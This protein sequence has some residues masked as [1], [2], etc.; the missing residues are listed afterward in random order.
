MIREAKP[1]LNSDY[2]NLIDVKITRKN[3]KWYLNTTEDKLKLIK[4]ILDKT[5]TK[6][7]NIDNRIVY[8]LILRIRTLH[9]IKKLIKK[10][11]YSKNDFVRVIEGIS[12][13]SY[14]RYLVVKNDLKGM[15]DGQGA[16]KR[17]VEKLYEYLKKE[18]KI[19]RGLVG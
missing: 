6:S 5:K 12:K 13:G 2:L 16:D 19:V 17:E 8:T 9:I 1:L 3:I 7:K 18:L 4:K 11:N 15:G 10:K 14:K